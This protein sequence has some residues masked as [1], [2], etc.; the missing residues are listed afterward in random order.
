MQTTSDNEAEE[1]GKVAKVSVRWQTMLPDYEK[2]RVEVNAWKRELE[3]EKEEKSKV[4]LKPIKKRINT[5]K[6]DAT[7]HRPYRQLPH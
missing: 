3:K 5:K 6:V 2:M 1:R 7:S 4:K